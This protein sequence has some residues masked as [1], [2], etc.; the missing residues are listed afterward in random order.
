METPVLFI[1]FN[2]PD[3]TKIVFEAIRQARPKSLYIAADGP[4]IDKAG[5]AE[6]CAATR[7]IVENIDWDCQVF[8]DFST[9][10][11]GCKSRVSSAI[12]WFFNNV[13]HGIILEDD[14]L[15]DP[16]F[17][18]FCETLLEKYKDDEKVMH[19]SGNNFL[20]NKIRIK[21]DYYF[22]RISNIWGWATWRRAWKKYD[23]D[24]KDFPEFIKENKI[25]KIFPDKFIQKKWLEL[26]QPVF[27]KKIDTWD[28]QWEYSIL[29]AG[30]LCINPRVN[31]VSN[32]GFSG[33]GTH[34]VRQ[35]KFANLKTESLNIIH[36][37][38]DILPNEIA[39]KLIM[40]N[41]FQMNH[42]NDFKKVIIKVAKFLKIK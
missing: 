19:I 38:K 31:L 25:A 12:S 4:R 15:P 7:A 6:K 41:N 37:P 5:E 40:K 32:I 9:A 3:T 21:D 11:L 14:C 28:Y 16:S 29:K 10:N 24:M 26:F 39:D 36:N 13:E 30:G 8:R 42:G 18:S 23:P 34:T 22:S 35:S 27:D 1:I 2:R 17:F 33:T 20:F